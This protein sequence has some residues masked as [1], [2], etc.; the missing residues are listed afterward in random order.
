MKNWK[1]TLLGLAVGVS[2]VS[3]NGVGW[4]QLLAATLFALLGIASKDFNV[5]GGNT[6]G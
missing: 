4:K 3:I 2:H 5:T 1:T 6:N